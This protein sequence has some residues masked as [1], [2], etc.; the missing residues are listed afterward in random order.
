MVTQAPK[1]TAI[2]AALTFTLSCVGL[3]IFVFTQFGGTI[4]F[5]AQGYRIKALFKET[6]LL[7]PNADVRISGVTIGKVSAVKDQGLNSLVTMQ[8]QPPYSPIP[9]DTR[10]ILRQKTLLGEAYVELSTGT[11]SGPKFT[12]GG[13]IPT[14]Q[15]QDTQALDQVLGGF[16]KPTQQNL[17]ALLNGTAISLAGR[18]QTLNDAIGN[19]DPTVTELSAMVGVLNDQGANLKKLI[20]SGAVVL[21]TLGARGHDLQSLV[22]AGNTVFATTAGRNSELKA[23]VNALPPFLRQLRTTLTT[24]DGTLSIAGPTLHVLRPVAPLFV[25]ALQDVI[26]LGG[27]ARRLLAQAPSLL[28]AANGALPAIERFTAAFHP[29]VDAILP[30]AQEVVP[31]INYI[32]VYRRELVAAMANLGASLEGRAPANTSSGTAAYLRAVSG[33][34][35]ESIFGQSIREPTS[36][37]N[38]YF[39]PG[40]LSNLASGGLKAASCAN[41]GNVS[42]VPLGF[43]NVPCVVQG[44]FNWGNGIASGY[45]PRLTRAPKPK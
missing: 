41:T 26:K 7:V 32:A 27:P 34:G 4:P 22:T 33:L 38:T 17:Q 25:P 18:G 29:A 1:K 14:S 5:S 11:G 28:S 31:I 39:A 15:V 45:Y 20:S 9:R 24:L 44:A 19:F 2:L 40:E 13:T 30:A 8:I 36:R 3:I 35:R 23:T 12:D 37:T 6:G 10:A 42:Q 43:G 21:G 16:D